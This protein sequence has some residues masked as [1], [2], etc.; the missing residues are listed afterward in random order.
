M[1]ERMLERMINILSWFSHTHNWSVP[2]EG[3]DTYMWRHCTDKS[4]NVKQRYEVCPA[5]DVYLWRSR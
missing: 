3:A 2:K 5:S 1:I 4:C